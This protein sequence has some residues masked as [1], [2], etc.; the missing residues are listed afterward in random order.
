MAATRMCNWA[1]V[2]LC[3]GKDRARPAQTAIVNML[4]RPGAALNKLCSKSSSMNHRQPAS[5]AKDTV[6]RFPCEAFS[7]SIIEERRGGGG[8][9]ERPINNTLTCESWLPVQAAS[10]WGHAH[11]QIHTQLWACT[12]AC[13]HTGGGELACRKAVVRNISCQ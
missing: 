12:T 6:S 13:M 4:Y 3:R 11:V 5:A 7:G 1:Y 10:L 9:A 2:L 8:G